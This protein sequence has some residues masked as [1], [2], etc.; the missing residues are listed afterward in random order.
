MTTSKMKQLCQTSSIFEVDNIKNGIILRDFRQK[1]EKH[2]PRAN[3]CRDFSIES[4]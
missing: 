4:V 1:R 3:A 2:W